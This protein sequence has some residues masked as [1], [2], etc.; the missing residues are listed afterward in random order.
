VQTGNWTGQHGT[1]LKDN[2]IV[3]D[4]EIHFSTVCPHWNQ[5]EGGG[6]LIMLISCC[7]LGFLTRRGHQIPVE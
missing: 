3:A 6:E 1:L 4:N 2:Y 7:F 5:R